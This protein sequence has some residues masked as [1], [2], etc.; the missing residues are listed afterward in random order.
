V[1]P[2]SDVDI[3][4]YLAKDVLEGKMRL[5]SS[6]ALAFD[7]ALDHRADTDVRAIKE[8]PLVLQGEILTKGILIYSK[9]DETRVSFETQTRMA[10]FDFKP[11]IEAYYRAYAASQLDAG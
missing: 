8:M 9:D 7:E 5:E 2:F 10:Y 3:A 6:I 4:V 11:V 1:H